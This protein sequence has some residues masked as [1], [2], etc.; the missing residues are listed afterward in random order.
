MTLRCKIKAGPL[1]DGGGQA[2]PFNK[3][4]NYGAIVTLDVRFGSGTDIRPKKSDV[5]FTPKS[6]HH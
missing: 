5:R 2:G 6:R 4:F 1:A 3:Y